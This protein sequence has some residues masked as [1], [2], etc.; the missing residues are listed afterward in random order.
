ML[1]RSISR[2]RI[3]GFFFMLHIVFSSWCS[4]KTV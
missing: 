2:R 4:I 3:G 1:S